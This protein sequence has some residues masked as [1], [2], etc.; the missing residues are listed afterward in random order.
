MDVSPVTGIPTSV[1][2]APRMN[3]AEDFDNFL[4][5]L[6]VQ[7]SNQ[8]PLDP[9]D[10]NEFVAQLVSFTGVEQAVNANSNLKKLIALFTASQSAAAVSYLGT[11]VIAKGDT[12]MLADGKAA[13]QYSL[14]ES[15]TQTNVLIADD[16]G[17]TVFVGSGSTSVGD[18]SF[19]WDGRDNNGVSQPDGAYKIS[20]TAK[21]ADDASVPVST[22]VSGRVSR[23]ETADGK[24]VLTVNGARVP[25]EDIV[26]VTESRPPAPST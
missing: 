3:L 22:T 8:D 13:F 6:T 20:I 21:T 16:T 25:F 17:K 1:A 9:V 24:I 11:T 5:L 14:T 12:T 26:S 18:H 19:V 10:S 4:T 23:V 2:E 7:L 15:T